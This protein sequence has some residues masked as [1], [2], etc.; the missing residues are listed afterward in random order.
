[1]NKTYTANIVIDYKLI[2]SVVLG[3]LLLS[4]IGFAFVS[5]YQLRIPVNVS[6]NAGSDL[7]NF[8][9]L[10]N[11]SEFMDTQ[12]L[13]ILD[14]CKDIR[15]TETDDT[16]LSYEFEDYDDS[17]YGCNT[18]DTLIWV[19]SPSLAANNT[20]SHF[21][22]YNN[23]A[24]TTFG[25]NTINTWDNGYFYVHHLSS[26]NTT[27]YFDSS[28]NNLDVEIKNNTWWQ[29][30]PTI[31][32]NGVRA[33]TTWYLE[34]L[35]DSQF[36]KLGDGRFT[37]EFWFNTSAA[38]TGDDWILN[39]WGATTAAKSFI[40]LYS[41]NKIRLIVHDGA[42]ETDIWTNDAITQ[43]QWNY[44][45][46]T[47]NTTHLLLYMNGVLNNTTAFSNDMQNSTSSLFYISQFGTNLLISPDD[48]Q[49]D[50]IR[51]NDN[52]LS[53]D[54]IA[55]N[56]A[57]Q[58]EGMT[59]LGD[60]ETVVIGRSIREIYDFSD[61]ALWLMIFIFFIPTAIMVMKASPV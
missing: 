2:V 17:V 53:A 49:L 48:M 15:I 52:D 32:G 37:I 4:G 30:I 38:S 61:L 45:A 43:N 47:Q 18:T 5:G 25:N 55:R 39:K 34:T 35:D 42:V 54:E 31:F 29:E 13:E 20:T 60:P 57:N 59:S 23:S 58:V 51:F 3:V 27:H 28:G 22:Q 1:M 50:E 6:S 10:L 8:T 19:R 26:N 40:I 9:Y 21:F 41:Q 14:D 16:L 46:V 56:Y 36:D 33:N 12:N 11:Y 7:T 24:E 44:Y